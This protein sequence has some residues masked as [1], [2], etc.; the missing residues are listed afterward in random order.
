MGASVGY[1]SDFGRIFDEELNRRNLGVAPS[2]RQE[3]AALLARASDT[4]RTTVRP[5]TV[6]DPEANALRFVS[7]MAE[8][9]RAR[10]LAELDEEAIRAAFFLCPLWPFC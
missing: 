1:L 4:E 2:A 3:L 6:Q 7:A 5:A 9:A 10:G 8:N